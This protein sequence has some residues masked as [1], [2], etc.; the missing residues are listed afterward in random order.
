MGGGGHLNGRYPGNNFAHVCV[1]YLGKY[2]IRFDKN[3]YQLNY[4]RAIGWKLICY[5]CYSSFFA[6]DGIK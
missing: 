4:H 2:K 5:I 1:L 6:I 3:R